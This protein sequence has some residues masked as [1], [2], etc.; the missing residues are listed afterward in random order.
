MSSVRGFLALVSLAAA[1]CL[2]RVPAQAKPGGAA[3]TVRATQVPPVLDYERDRGVVVARVD[4][5]DVT[6][7]E[8]ATHQSKYDP[9]VVRRWSTPSGSRE[10]N[11][12]ALPQL[13]YQYVDLVCL[14]A[15][16]KAKRVELA[17]LAALIERNIA[18]SFE[19]YVQQI[20]RSKRGQK[21]S[22]DA[23]A[24]YE[25]RHRRERGM[26][27]EIRALQ[28]LLLPP[29]YTQSELRAWYVDNGDVFGGKVR[30]AHILLSLR[31]RAT[32]RL[33]PASER[34]RLRALAHDLKRRLDKDPGLFPELARKHSDDRVTKVRG[35]EFNAWTGRINRRLPAVVV[36]AAWG[37]PDGGISA[38]V[39]SYYGLHIVRRIK[40]S[41]ERYILF[42]GKTIR[43]ITN[44]KSKLD[45]EELL[46]E[47]RKRHQ[48]ERRI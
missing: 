17:N 35:G 13:V 41:V 34:R 30:F 28:T 5:Q 27:S 33:K 2:S 45:H 12:P 32:G 37:Q 20:R 48:I 31:D 14:R 6:L 9:G 24:Y 8:L 36:R 18:K 16:A 4:G 44:L 23:I 39:E 19:G 26:I 29:R 7:G 3:A 15:E 40:Q 38:P 25:R 1:G 11:G 10:L 46:I 21:I 47:M 42:H 22:K 43:R